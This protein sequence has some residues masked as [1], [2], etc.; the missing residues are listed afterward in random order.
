MLWEDMMEDSSCQ[1]LLDGPGHPG[2]TSGLLAYD[3]TQHTGSYMYMAPEIFRGEPYNES[4]DVFSLG[5]ILYELFSR[6]LLLYTHTPANSPADSEAYAARVSRGFRPQRPTNFHAGVWRVVERCWAADPTARPAAAWVLQQLQQLLVAEEAAAAQAALHKSSSGVAGVLSRLRRPGRRS[7]DAHPA[8][9]IDESRE[10]AAAADPAAAAAAAG[11]AGVAAAVGACR[12][13]SRA[14]AGCGSA[15]ASGAS[16][17][18]KAVVVAAVAGSAGL[19]DKRAPAAC[20]AAGV[21][22]GR[23]AAGGVARDKAAESSCGCVIC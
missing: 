22:A 23:G 19:Q 11:V 8:A 13:D 17:D 9:R 7:V 15:A 1:E 4:V 5:V 3:L 20:G 14:E 18:G 10:S 2:C 12:A 21:A 16:G 6:S